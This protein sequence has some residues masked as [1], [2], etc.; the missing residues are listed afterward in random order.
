MNV[1]FSRKRETE[2]LKKRSLLLALSMNA[3]NFAHHIVTVMTM[4]AVLYFGDVGNFKASNVFSILVI[5]FVMSFYIRLFQGQGYF[6]LCEIFFGTPKSNPISAGTYMLMEIKNSNDRFQEALL[7]PE[8]S[9][10]ES[11][12]KKSDFKNIKLSTIT[13][14]NSNTKFEQYSAIYPGQEKP[15]LLNLNFEI[16]DGTLLGVIGPVGSGKSTL[17][18]VFI[19][20]TDDFG[21][22]KQIPSNISIA[23]QEAWIFEGSIRE[24]IL[25][26]AEFDEK[27]YN[28]VV[29]AVCLIPDFN[30]LPNGD[31]TL[32][33]YKGVTLSGGQRARVGLA[34]AIYAK[35][36]IYILDDPLAAV[37]PE[38]AA[39]IYEKCVQGILKKKTRI[40]ITHQ[41]KFLRLVDE[42]LR[43]KAY[44]SSTMFEIV[45]L[46][47]RCR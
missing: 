36:D 14:S 8:K 9:I 19:G 12:P 20:E 13:E 11:E 40:L 5:A 47:K 3:V 7:L 41:Y 1:I 29:Q 39:Q 6:K 2:H 31:Q 16:S 21:G 33:G 45:S 10:I 23:P 4:V 42:F 28:E 35:S 25:I 15:S 43:S 18:N 46:S 30:I 26:G 27:F 37:D 34:R 32:V 38:V 22:T 24:N 17:L 44:E